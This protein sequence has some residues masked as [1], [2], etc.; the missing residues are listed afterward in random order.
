MSTTTATTATTTAT[1]VRGP[2]PHVARAEGGARWYL[3]LAARYA[4]AV[5]LFSL[6]LAALLATSTAHGPAD[7][8]R[9]AFL[10]VPLLGACALLFLLAVVPLRF[11][12][13]LPWYAGAVLVLPTVPLLLLLGPLPLPLVALH[14]VF[15]RWFLPRPVFRLR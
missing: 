11:S 7:A 4:L 6:A 9:R 8:L 3:R 5:A 12:P 1:T 15:A 13:H 14:L 10:V 2:A